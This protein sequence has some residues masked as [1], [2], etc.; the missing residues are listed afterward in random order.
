MIPSRRGSTSG[1]HRLKMRRPPRPAQKSAKET[2]KTTHSTRK[3]PSRAV[4]NKKS[5]YFDP[6]TDDGEFDDNAGPSEPE[7]DE[8]PKKN[9]ARKK[10]TKPT[11]Q[12]GKQKT[13]E[14][15]DEEP[16][17]TFV[18]K[19]DTPDAGDVE[20]KNDTIHPNTLQFLRGNCRCGHAVTI[21]LAQNNEREW[22]WAH[23][24]R[25]YSISV[26]VETIS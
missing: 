7:Y 6:P 24:V 22:F 26:D 14:S 10:P 12:K 19:E 15:E 13:E 23:E 11:P 9:P 17:E 3:R 5:K 20:Y 1:F 4:R 18:P 21:D 8:Q 2:I 16:W 25:S